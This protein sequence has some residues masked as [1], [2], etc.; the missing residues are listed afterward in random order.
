MPV[1]VAAPG[2]TSTAVT[3]ADTAT[4]T[5]SD[6]AQST[7]Q[8]VEVVELTTPTSR[9]MAEPNGTFTLTSSREPVRVSRAGQW[10]PIDAT[11]T[12]NSDGSFSPRATEVEL[13]F[14][15]GGAG[16]ALVIGDPG[17]DASI[18]ISWTSLLPEPTITGDTATYADVLPGVD[19]VLTAKGSSYA[20][21]LVVHDAQAAANPE[22]QNLQML[23]QAHRL[24]L[25][26]AADGGLNATDGNG[27]RVFVG[28]EATV[29]DS[30]FEPNYGA[31]P[32]ASDPGGASTT[33]IP[34]SIPQLDGSDG[35]ASATAILH[36]PHDALLGPD[37]QYPVF[38]DPVLSLA[39]PG[40]F[41]VVSSGT[42]SLHNYDTGSD[43]KVG[44]CDWGAV[45]NN[46]GVARSF[47]T[48][49]IS[50][51]TGQFYWQDT[52]AQ[53]FDAEVDVYQIH[54]GA[55]CTAQPVTLYTTSAF[56]GSTVWPGPAF[57]TNLGSVSTG[58]SDS[59]G[60][61]TGGYDKFT[62]SAI[63]GRLEYAATLGTVITFGLRSPDETN[64]DQWKRFNTNP[65]LIAHYS[66]APSRLTATGISGAVSCNGQ[67]YAKNQYPVLT[68]TAHDNNYPHYPLTMRF[69]L[70]NDGGTALLGY[71]D[72]DTT[73]NAATSW[74][75]TYPTVNGTRY[76]YG[77]NARVKVTDPND[78]SMQWGVAS[79]H[80]SFI[81]AYNSP[82]TTVSVGSADY[83]E[84]NWGITAAQPG[85]F[86]LRNDDAAVVGF[87]YRFDGGAGSEP[88]PTSCTS[89]SVGSPATSGWIMDTQGQAT[90]T[91]PAGLST[92]RHVL[93]VK[94]FNGALLPSSS[95]ETAYAFYVA[96]GVG[97]PVSNRA[98]AEDGSRVSYPATS[99]IAGASVANANSSTILNLKRWLVGADRLT[100]A[101]P[102]TPGGGVLQTGLGLIYT[103]AAMPSTSALY[104]CVNGSDHFT[105][106]DPACEG[107]TRAS[108]SAMGYLYASQPTAAGSPSTHALY[109][110]RT[111][112]GDHF[113]SSSSNC[114]GGSNLVEGILGYALDGISDLSSPKLSS[115]SSADGARYVATS[116]VGSQFA[117]TFAVPVEADYAVGLELIT[118]P[119]NGKISFRIAPSN[120]LNAAV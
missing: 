78:P 56:S 17:S 54:N 94:A 120:N 20:E 31:R 82:N 97:T 44:K 111:S 112:A 27:D 70:Y 65:Q 4:D 84:G 3:T 88:T 77:V 25:T 38:I 7:G 72:R 62:S 45:C 90:I 61:G 74:T 114:E 21:T 2:S 16:P 96:P 60:T 32:T 67:L 103:G 36:T 19:L 69:S 59:C 33:P 51:L 80:L 6:Q 64:R 18:S 35:N 116:S 14:S 109:R 99:V 79:S 81:A 118:G 89:T 83:P 8:P 41:L 71:A 117:V 52:T 46:I 75:D 76:E 66:Y 95:Y 87:T 34:A 110:C 47:F 73:D 57:G 93:Y 58:Y 113:D 119:N 98:E 26:E 100:M 115:L 85:S 24:D 55:G 22:L 86:A 105:S 29:W 92:G 23:F 50:A 11:L 5:A 37:V 15:G 13:T 1:A 102:A 48:F 30:S 104:D 39:N 101:G 63:A 107:R 40:H 10:T 68:G 28:A 49:D 9:V 12:R 106:A 108:S 53:V 91:A 42:T 43:L